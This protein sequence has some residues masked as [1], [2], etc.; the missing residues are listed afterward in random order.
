MHMKTI[1]QLETEIRDFI[2][3]PRKQSLLLKDS[4]VWN[5][6]CSAL[7]V[8][9]DTELAINAYISAINVNSDGEA[10]LIVYGILQVLLVQQDAVK[11]RT[12]LTS[13]IMV[14]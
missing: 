7:D 11:Y 1:E 6:L 8:T 3:N 13:F 9:G 12:H 4:T 14:K 2:N 5:K 10:Y